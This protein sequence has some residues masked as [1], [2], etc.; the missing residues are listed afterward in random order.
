MEFS[1]S[2]SRAF[3]FRKIHPLIAEFILSIPDTIDMDQLSDDAQARLFPAAT[4]D[5]Q[6]ETLRN[7]WKA[8]V[9]P[10][11]Q[12]H[13]RSAREVV[14]ADLKQM[15]EVKG[16]VELEIAPAHGEAWLNAL[17]QAR[18][19]LAS[20]LD[21]DEQKLSSTNADVTTESGSRV[22]RLNLFAFM[23]ECL[24]DKMG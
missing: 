12:E 11:L 24:I 13:F 4:D 7:E 20:D 14:A 16:M 9:E 23:Q 1:V 10:D 5:P 15:R 18:L 19:V 17:N 8:Y 6:F 21:F 2:R 22:F 3:R